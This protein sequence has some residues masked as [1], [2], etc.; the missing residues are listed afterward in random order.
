M[1]K[2]KITYLEDFQVYRLNVDYSEKQ[3]LTCSNCMRD[4]DVML[5]R[6][7]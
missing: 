6:I 7:V 5:C 3:G 4:S 2:T 1:D